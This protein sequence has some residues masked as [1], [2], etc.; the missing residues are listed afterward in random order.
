MATMAVALDRNLFLAYYSSLIYNSLHLYHH[1]LAV[2]ID[3]ERAYHM[4]HVPTLLKKLL[5]MGIMG[6][7][8]HW[9]E[10]I[11]IDRTFQVKVGASLS[12]THSLENGTPQGSIISPILFLIMINDIPHGLDG[13]EMSLFADDSSI[14]AGHRNHSKLQNKIQLSLNSIYAWCNK[15]G[16]KIS[17]SKTVCVLFTKKNRVPNTSIKV[18]DERI[19][20]EKSAKFLGSSFDYRLSWKPHNY[21]IHVCYCQVQEPYEFD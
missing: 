7:T 4:L 9:I 11:L 6:K 8:Y 2:L 10:K 15:N 13:V 14:S 16:F 18:G 19:K 17:I 20:I 1:V 21:R 12:E 5:N 3:F